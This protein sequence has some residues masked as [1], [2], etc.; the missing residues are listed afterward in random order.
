[1]FVVPINES[2][3]IMENYKMGVLENWELRALFGL[4][5]KV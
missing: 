5:E 2:V 3:G 1:V 4:G